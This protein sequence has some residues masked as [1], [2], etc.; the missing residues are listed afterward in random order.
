MSYIENALNRHQQDPKKL[1]CTIR[2]F[3]SSAKT[4][5]SHINCIDN[6]TDDKEIANLMNAFF[7][8]TGKRVQANILSNASLDDFDYPSLPPSFEFIQN[9]TEDVTNAINSLS[10]SLAG[11]VDDITALMIKSAKMESAPILQYMYNLSINTRTFAA[12]W[13]IS[14]VTPLFKSGDPT[15]VNNYRPIS[16][17][18]VVGKILERIIHWQ[19]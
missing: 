16:I 11:S 9:S 10:S 12:C 17:I 6:I 1:W 18:P 8:E 14:K 15:D 19:C 7:C 4:S 13:K 5:N 2:T 3:W